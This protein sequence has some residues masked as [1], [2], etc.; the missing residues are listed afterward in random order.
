MVAGEE[1]ESSSSVVLLGNTE[2]LDHLSFIRQCAE[3][4]ARHTVQCPNASEIRKC[5]KEAGIGM[6][7]AVLHGLS[8][9]A[10]THYKGFV[11]M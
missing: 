3:H 7:L 4:C 2:P 6:G 11:G 8:R 9:A 1:R 10:D 5:G